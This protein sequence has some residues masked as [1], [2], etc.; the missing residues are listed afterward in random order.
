MAWP[1]RQA[2]GH[3]K[4]PLP[5]KDW[6]CVS[7]YVSSALEWWSAALTSRDKWSVVTPWAAAAKPRAL[8]VCRSSLP[9][10][11]ATVECV[12]K[13]WKTV[14]STPARKQKKSKG[15]TDQ[16]PRLDA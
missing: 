4:W 1:L 14:P 2:L 5:Q 11:T 6:G 3:A 7:V 10:D 8:D 9:G 12:R 13:S 16:Q 15:E